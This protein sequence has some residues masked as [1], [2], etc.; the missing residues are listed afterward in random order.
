MFNETRSEAVASLQIAKMGEIDLSVG[1]FQI[2]GKGFQIK[3]DGTT[4]VLLE[5]SLLGM[6]PGEFVSTKFD[7]GWN[8][9]IVREI[10]QNNLS[11]IILKW[12]F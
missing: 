3:N 6:D 10:K 2:E 12:G 11:N 9:E 7:V 5:V 4:E 1:N 8:P